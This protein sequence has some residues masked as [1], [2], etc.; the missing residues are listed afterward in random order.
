MVKIT[1]LSNTQQQI[2]FT[3]DKFLPKICRVLQ[4]IRT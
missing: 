1:N 2:A 4:D 3:E